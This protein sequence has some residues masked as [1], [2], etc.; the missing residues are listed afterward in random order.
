MALRP[1]SPNPKPRRFYLAAAVE[2]AA[3]GFA[4]TLDGRT[5]KTPAGGR[6]IA[7]TRALADAISAEWAA[8]VEVINVA[9]M[10]LTRLAFTALDRAADAH[11]ALAQSLARHAEADVLCYLAEA[12]QDLRAR[13]IAQWSP[14]LDWA[15]DVLGLHFVTATGVVHVPQ[16]PETLARVAELARA[17]DGFSLTGLAFAAGL[18][19][20]AILALAVQR[21]RLSGPDAFALSRLE[22]AYQEDRWGVDA[23]AAARTERLY[24]DAVAVERWFEGAGRTDARLAP[25]DADA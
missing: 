19:D 16:P 23:E 20:S 24:R 3:T 22:E 17:L 7:P 15:R 4:V 10:P 18:F 2:D 1:D 25:A 8:Q 12:P 6:L 11:D 14:V 21:K 13:Q 9:A 5:A